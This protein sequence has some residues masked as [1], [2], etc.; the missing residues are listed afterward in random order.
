MRIAMQIDFFMYIRQETEEL[1]TAV[2][3]VVLVI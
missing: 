2:I 1:R 3:M